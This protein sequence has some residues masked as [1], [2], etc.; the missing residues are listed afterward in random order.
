MDAVMFLA[1]KSNEI[2]E[3]KQAKQCLQNKNMNN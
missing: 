2:N 3:V 1:F